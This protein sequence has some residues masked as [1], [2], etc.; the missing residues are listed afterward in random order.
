MGLFLSIVSKL[1]RG[2]SSEY[3]LHANKQG[4]G[5]H[6]IC[7]SKARCAARLGS[8]AVQKAAQ[9]QLLLLLVG[10]VWWGRGGEAVTEV[11]SRS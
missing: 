10:G 7:A 5:L 4:A 2:T 11:R 1:G 9:V 6:A 3:F 8:G